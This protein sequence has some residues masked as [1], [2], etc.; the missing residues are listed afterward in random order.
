MKI[1]K[2]YQQH[3]LAG[4]AY[5]GR[6]DEGEEEWSGSDENWTKLG[7]LEDGVSAEAI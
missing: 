4:L 3:F 6:N 7:W 2:Y 5:A 1:A